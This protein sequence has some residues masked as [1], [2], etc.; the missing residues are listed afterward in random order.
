M[1]LRNGML[2]VKEL[3]ARDLTPERERERERFGLGFG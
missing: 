1:D 2:H 3:V